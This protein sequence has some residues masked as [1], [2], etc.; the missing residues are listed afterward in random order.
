MLANP[1]HLTESHIFEYFPGYAIDASATLL[2]WTLM[3][4]LAFSQRGL[5]ILP[6]GEPLRARVLD[7]GC[8]GWVPM[9]MDAAGR[10]I[11]RTR[12]GAA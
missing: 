11:E 12:A 5:S 10:A 9:G 1:N 8:D 3:G 4:A 7:V 6:S 2:T